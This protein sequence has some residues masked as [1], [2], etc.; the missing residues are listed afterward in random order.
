MTNEKELDK[1]VLRCPR[2]GGEVPF[3]YC[4]TLQN[5][6]PC[7]RIIICWEL[8]FDI[9][10]YIQEHYKPTEIQKFLHPKPKD[11][12]TTLLDIIEQAKRNVKKAKKPPE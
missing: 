2:L 12:M 10:A 9:G 7:D 4:R 5:G 8:V 11:K 3:S 1:Q 6:M